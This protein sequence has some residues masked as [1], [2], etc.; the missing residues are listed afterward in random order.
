L[1]YWCFVNSPGARTYDVAPNNFSDRQIG[2]IGGGDSKAIGTTGQSSLVVPMVFA[3]IL[4]GV[5]E[6]VVIGLGIR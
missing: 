6:S 1:L 5:P 2:K 3:I 4:D